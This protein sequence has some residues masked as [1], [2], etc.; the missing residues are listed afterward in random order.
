MAKLSGTKDKFANIAFLEVT[1]SAANTLTF[2]QLQLATT[3]M[4]EKAALIIHRAELTVDDSVLNSSGDYVD[5]A[6]AVSDRIPSISDLSQPELLFYMSLQRRDLGTAA[7]GIILEWPLQ[8]DFTS[9]P[10]GGILVPADRLYIGIKGF[11]AASASKGTMRL[12]YT[13]MA[14][15]TEDYWDL[16]EARRVM[17]T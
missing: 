10:G 4:T 6:L 2:A 11:G 9:L 15:N 5:V 16:I 3:L 7:S 8:A 13:I 1:E 17:T 14:L 12:Y